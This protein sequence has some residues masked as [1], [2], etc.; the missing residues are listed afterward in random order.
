MGAVM[1]TSTRNAAVVSVVAVTMAALAPT[2]ATAQAA[3]FR[4]YYLN[5]GE[6]YQASPF[7]V[8]AAADFQ[9]LRLM[10][11]PRLGP[12][13]L[14]VAYEQTLFWQS[15]GPP[16]GV[17]LGAPTPGESSASGDWL[18]LDG[19]ILD[20]PH[21]LWRQRAD[22]LA[23]DFNV[24]P[25]QVTAGRQAIS[26]ATTLLLTPAD[27]FAPFDPSDP[28][29]EYRAGV[30]ALRAQYYAGPFTTVDL[31]VR[32]QRTPLGNSTTVLL[33]GRTTLGS[34][35]VSAWLG[36]LYDKLA[37]ALGAEGSIGGWGLRS[38]AEL[39]GGGRVTVRAAA[40]V[41]RRI[42]VLQRDLNLVAEYQHDGFGAADAGGLL[43]VLES[44][45]YRRGEMQVL[46]RD[47]W[48]VQAAWQ[49][50]PLVSTE[51][52][53]LQDLRDGSI[54]VAPALAVSVS[55]DVSARI[56]VFAGVGGSG[57]TATRALRSEYGSVPTFGYVSLSAFF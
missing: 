18:R 43:A 55:N 50:H 5:V 10:V 15:A 39:R 20:R 9:R 54:L 31:V 45:A 33:R 11:A 49:V 23:A 53:G 41:D 30:D 12:L 36:S 38:E 22:R 46:G 48:L 32:P 13:T 40:G 4:G 35:A 19:T 2:A 21:W 24:G 51:F 37:G 57:L 8:G 47:E 34:W 7:A 56:G 17:Q 25:V 52:L 42:T 27:P 44:A 16:G 29:R 14:D 1:R 28:F 26:W 3:G 6:A